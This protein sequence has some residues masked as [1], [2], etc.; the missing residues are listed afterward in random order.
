[1]VCFLQVDGLLIVSNGV[2]IA[3][4]LLRGVGLLG[5]GAKIGITQAGPEQVARGIHLRGFIQSG[6]GGFEIA[7][8]HGLVGERQFFVQRLY[9]VDFLGSLFLRFLHLLQLLGD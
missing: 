4:G 1:M 5:A 2:A 8:L 9:R 6:D 3:L 7:R